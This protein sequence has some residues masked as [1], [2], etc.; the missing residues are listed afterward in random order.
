MG[1]RYYL[2]LAIGLSPHG[3]GKPSLGD[4]SISRARSIPARAGETIALLH[5]A[6]GI[7]GLSPHG[8]G[9]RPCPSARSRRTG[10]IPARAGETLVLP[11]LVSP[12][13][14]Y[15]RTGGGNQKRQRSNMVGTGLS[16]HGRGKPWDVSSESVAARSI[17][18]RAGET[19]L[20][21][22]IRNQV[23]VYPRTGGGNYGSA[24]PNSQF[25]G[26]SPHGRG[27]LYGRGCLAAIHRSIPARAGETNPPFSHHPQP[28]VYPRTGGGNPRPTPRSAISQGLSPHGRGK[29]DE[30]Q[31]KRDSQRSIPARAGETFRFLC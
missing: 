31:R 22:V 16:P 17:P 30:R 5:V 19:Q 18:A 4:S 1:E 14:V 13:K 10:S 29:R 21:P 26:L 9:K 12:L 11:V 23:W 20:S 25:N 7:T 27:K 6:I 2:C 3:R 24:T 28:E 15:P 8:R